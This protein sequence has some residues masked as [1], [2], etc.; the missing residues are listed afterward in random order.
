M[1]YIFKDTYQTT[2]SQLRV[3]TVVI[4]VVAACH[5]RLEGPVMQET[6]MINCNII[7]TVT[8]SVMELTQ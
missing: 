1:L 8:F 4:R 2:Y 7:N 6:F 5:C 3:T